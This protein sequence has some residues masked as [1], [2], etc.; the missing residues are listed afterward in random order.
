MGV[1]ERL[2]GELEQLIKL[3]KWTLTGRVV[4]YSRTEYFIWAFPFEAINLVVGA[5]A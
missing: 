3:I 1:A 5:L 4:A 2:R